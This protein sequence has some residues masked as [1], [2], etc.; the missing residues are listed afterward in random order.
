MSGGHLSTIARSM[1][2]YAPE[3][4]WTRFT[5]NGTETRCV[6][7]D[8]DETCELGQAKT[9]HVNFNSI[10]IVTIN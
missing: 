6:D 9:K 3:M 4:T 5:D 8:I 10:Y 7:A 2:V 1:A